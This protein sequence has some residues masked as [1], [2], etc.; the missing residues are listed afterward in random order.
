MKFVLQQN[1]WLTYILQQVPNDRF[2]VVGLR[3]ASKD[4]STN[5]TM[6][7]RNLQTTTS[8]VSSV[9]SVDSDEEPS[10]G[11]DRNLKASNIRNLQNST[12]PTSSVD[13]IDENPDETS[14]DE[15]TSSDEVSIVPSSIGGALQTSALEVDLAESGS[16]SSSFSF[17]ACMMAVGMVG[18]FL[19]V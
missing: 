18:T 13:S 7:K 1:I 5:D 15:T 8:S 6:I 17:T 10:S 9:D 2:L 16:S 4:H 11:D 19:V 3:G 12:S 14:S